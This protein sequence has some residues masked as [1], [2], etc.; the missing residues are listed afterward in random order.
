[1]LTLAVIGTLVVAAVPVA[2]DSTYITIL[3]GG[4][5]YPISASAFAGLTHISIPMVF[6][7]I[8]KS[9]TDNLASNATSGTNT[10]VLTNI[11][12]LD[13]SGNSN[14][15]RYVEFGISPNCQHQCRD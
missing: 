7:Y 4:N 10:V 15:F 1:M 6:E 8:G 13:G 5:R 14:H 12:G 2:A 11:L 9:V 3:E